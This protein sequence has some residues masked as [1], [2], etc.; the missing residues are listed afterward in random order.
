MLDELKLT[1]EDI[2][3]SSIKALAFRWLSHQGVVTVLLFLILGSIIYGGYYGM[4]TAIPQHLNQI[5]TGYQDV[6][7]QATT[8]HRKAVEAIERSH[9]A[10]RQ[11][12]RELLRV[13]KSG[14]GA[15][16]TKPGD[17][18]ALQ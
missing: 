17:A 14:N 10:E 15:V 11:L 12:Y 2:D 1:N 4:T 7:E 6:I 3:K 5:Q 9:D 8:E 13:P 16:A 18:E